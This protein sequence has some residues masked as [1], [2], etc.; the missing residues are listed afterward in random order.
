MV[1][2]PV[3]VRIRGAGRSEQMTREC[4]CLASGW[5]VTVAQPQDN[6]GETLV[7]LDMRSED[8]AVLREY[9]DEA[10]DTLGDLGPRAHNR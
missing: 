7:S 10:A 2:P 5:M 6:E 1:S 9:A 4:V 8:A 3:T